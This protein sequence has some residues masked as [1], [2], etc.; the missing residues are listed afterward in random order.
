[1]SLIRRLIVNADD[2]G[3][4]PG[5]SRGILESK[6]DDLR[7]EKIEPGEIRLYESQLHERNFIDRIYDTYIDEDDLRACDDTTKKIFDQF[8]KYRDDQILWSRFAEGSFDNLML[9]MRN[10]SA[11]S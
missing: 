6:P 8:A 10:P 5:V 9:A 3:M 11:K 4:T 2:F 1:M 7:R